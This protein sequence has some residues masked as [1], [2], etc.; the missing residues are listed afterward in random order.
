M[1]KVKKVI[2]KDGMVQVVRDKKAEE[3]DKQH[4]IAIMEARQEAYAPESNDD[5]LVDK[6]LQAIKEGQQG[7][8]LSNT[9][10][11]NTKKLEMLTGRGINVH[12]YPEEMIKMLL[13]GDYKKQLHKHKHHVT[14]FITELLDKRFPVTKLGVQTKLYKLVRDFKKGKGLFLDENGKVTKPKRKPHGK[15]ALLSKPQEGGEIL[16]P[17][18]IEKEEDNLVTFFKRRN[19]LIV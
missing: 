17:A 11:K 6:I 15:K 12:E 5:E 7:K 4:K 13:D 9:Y 14:R 8:G 1:V 16:T 18:T 10:I 2:Y 3:I 19:G